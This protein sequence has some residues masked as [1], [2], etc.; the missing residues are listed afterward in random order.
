MSKDKMTMSDA[1]LTAGDYAA[2]N[3]CIQ[4]LAE[5]HRQACVASSALQDVEIADV[6][7]YGCVDELVRL[8]RN[9]EALHTLL[10]MCQDAAIFMK[11]GIHAIFEARDEY[12]KQMERKRKEALRREE[13]YR[14]KQ[15]SNEKQRK[16][17][18]DVSRAQ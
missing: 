11:A 7:D 4:K 12:E 17:Q 13:E 1:L 16:K 10:S 18:P 9:A 14:R 5:L 8:K 2:T 6:Y 3:D 15:K